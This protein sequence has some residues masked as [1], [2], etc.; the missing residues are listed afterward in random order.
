MNNNK[1]LFLWGAIA[2]AI[3][4]AVIIFLFLPTIT[5]IYNPPYAIYITF[6]ILLSIKN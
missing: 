3:L 6:I 1:R 4:A 2:V 5:F